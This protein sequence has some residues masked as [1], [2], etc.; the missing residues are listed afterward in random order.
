MSTTSVAARVRAPRPLFRCRRTPLA[1]ALLLGLGLSATGHAQQADTDKEQARQLDTVTVIGQREPG[2]FAIDAGEIDLTQASNLGDVLSNQ[3][4]VAVGGGSPVAQKVYVRGFE[5]T[6]LN[7]SIDGAQQPAELYHHQARVQ[8]EPEFIKSIELDAGAG[9][10]TQGAGALTGAMKVTTRNAFDML[11]RYG[12]EGRD[13]GVLIKGAAGSNGADSAKGVL[14]AYARLGDNL[15]VLATHVRQHGGDYDDGNGDRVAPTGYDHERSQLRLNGLFG[16]HSGEFSAEHLLDTGTYYERPH[17]TNFA[18]RFVLSDHRMQRDTASYSHRFD[19]ESEAVDVQANVYYSNNRYD[20]HRNTTGALYGRAEQATRGL[21][22]RNT[23]R[24]TGLE[25]VYGAEYRHDALEARQQ[26]TPPAFWASTEQSASV[27]GVYAQATWTPAD[28]WRISAGLRWDDYDLHVESG[29]GAGV[30]NSARHASPNLSVEWQPIPALTLR[31]A[32]AQAFRG[33]TIREGFFS[34]LYAHH[35]D[36][37]GEQADNLELGIAWEHDGWFARATVFRQDIEN[38]INALYTGGANEW[39]YWANLGDADVK[40]YEL[41]AGRKWDAFELGLGVWNSDNRFAD[42][43]LTDADLGLGTSIGRTWTARFDWA[44][45]GHAGRY[46][47]RARHVEREANLITPTA[48]PKPAYTVV[49]LLSEWKLGR[50]QQFSIGIALNNLLNEFYYDHA[51]YGYHSS[52]KYIGF[53]AMG[54]ELR[55]S[56]GVHF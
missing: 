17:M 25:L 18:G 52:G 29:P 33:V 9:T 27:L 47:L 11:Q 35:G 4:G 1:L 34:A 36:L 50:A 6:L 40:G 38:Y 48:P 23:M 26:A 5:D 16:D 46:G 43:A 37:E 3:S 41:E 2:N 19:P 55:L 42:K 13:V 24:W 21:D 49:D 45:Q 28:P 51:T 8:I 44:P 32:Y 54:R 20:N 12:R 10:A 31:A 39:G 22:L 15:G 14:A 30:R 53:P 7:V 56:L